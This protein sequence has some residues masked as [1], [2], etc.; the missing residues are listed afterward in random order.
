[1]KLIKKEKKMRCGYYRWVESSNQYAS[2]QYA[3]H[4]LEDL[5]QYLEELLWRLFCWGY[6]D[7]AEKFENSNESEDLGQT[8]D[9]NRKWKVWIISK[10]YEKDVL[11]Q[12]IF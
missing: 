1:M 11:L 5:N 12:K 6:P 7:N 10:I 4:Q 3:S 9:L 8:L 2:H